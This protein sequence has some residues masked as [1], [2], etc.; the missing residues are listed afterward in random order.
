MDALTYRLAWGRSPVV[1]A[2]FRWRQGEGADTVLPY[3]GFRAGRS[4]VRPDDTGYD[5]PLAPDPPRD[6]GPDNPW[7]ADIPDHLS[8][9]VIGADDP[10]S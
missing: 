9:P 3:R 2:L 7:L 4:R 1:R 6:S 10:Q 5:E 8:G